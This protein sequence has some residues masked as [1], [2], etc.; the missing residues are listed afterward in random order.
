MAPQK[1]N[2]YMHW[3][4][5]VLTLIVVPFIAKIDSRNEKIEARITG[6]EVILAKSSATQESDHATVSDVRLKMMGM[7]DKQENHESRISVVE[8]ILTE[9][10]RKKNSP[11]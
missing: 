7:G 6:I 3:V 10:R 1:Q 9:I 5:L 8:A 11:F 2:N 4:Q